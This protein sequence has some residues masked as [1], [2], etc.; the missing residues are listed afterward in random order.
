MYNTMAMPADLMAIGYYG[1]RPGT[2]TGRSS[3]NVQM[4]PAGSQGSVDNKKRRIIAPD[5]LI[6]TKVD[7]AKL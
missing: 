7:H 5:Y 1:Y 2:G 4:P 6:L 3:S